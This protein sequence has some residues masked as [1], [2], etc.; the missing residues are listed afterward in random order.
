MARTLSLEA[1]QL[2]AASLGLVAFLGLTGYALDRAFTDAAVSSEQERMKGYSSAYLAG[3]EFTRN[4]DFEPPYLPPDPRFTQP[5]SG[6]Y[7]AVL[8]PKVDWRSASTLD[9]AL[10]LDRSVPAGKDAFDGP[11][12]VPDKNGGAPEHLYRYARG[13]IWEQSIGKQKTQDIPFTFYVFEDANVL[14]QHVEV[15]RRA[16]WGYL[17][18]AALL[19]LGVQALILRWSLQPL[20]RMR[21]E[22]LRVQRGNIERMSSSHPRELEPLTDSINA[23]IVSEREHME[24]YRNTLSDLAH[25][26]KT[27]L[28]VLRARLADDVSVEELRNDVHGQVQRMSEIVSYQLSRGAT[29][30]HKLFAVPLEIEALAEGIVVSLEKVYAGKRVLC[31]FDLDAEARFHGAQG[32]LME[33]LGNLLENAFKWAKQRVLLSSRNEVAAGRRRPGLVLS[34]ED[35]GPGIPDD[36]VERLLQR[37]VRGDERVQGHGIGLSIVQNI[38]RAYNGE[39]EVD[40]S[41]ELGG[42][43][44]TVR[45]PPG[46]L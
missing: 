10:P 42:T 24:R 44:F 25:S 32:D 43:R 40:R 26:L 5:S 41:P 28:A 30:G 7:A 23:F 22:L 18:A 9:R 2:L 16:L 17:G 1:R 37:G 12:D 6:L 36:S 19:L 3:G 14:R 31:E 39:L 21:R 35:D 8:G 46:L 15:F 38:V 33:L 45:I 29:A 4:Q 34:V 27:P 11:I 20:R 13:I